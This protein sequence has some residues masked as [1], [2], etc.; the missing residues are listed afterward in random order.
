MNRRMGEDSI[1]TPVLR[2]VHARSRGIMIA[3]MAVVGL[4]LVSCYTSVR[5]KPQDGSLDT[6]DPRVEDPGP[7]DLFM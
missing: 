3:C 7:E 4:F 1:K 2:M 6:P 5:P